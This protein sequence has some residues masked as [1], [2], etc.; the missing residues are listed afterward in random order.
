MHLGFRGRTS[1]GPMD[2]PRFRRLLAKYLG[3]DPGARNPWFIDTVAAIDDPGGRLIRLVPD[4][5]FTN[6]VS[7]FRTGP[8]L[9]WP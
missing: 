1:V 5:T 3:P 8:D 9:A 6:N 2:P 7:F 4:T